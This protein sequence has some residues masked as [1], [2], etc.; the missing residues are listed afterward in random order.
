MKEG[1]GCEIGHAPGRA[2]GL[3]HRQDYVEDAGRCPRR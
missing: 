2:N 3:C 1:K